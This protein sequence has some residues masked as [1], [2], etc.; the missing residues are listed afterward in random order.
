MPLE[1]Q[2]PLAGYY[3][4]LVNDLDRGRVL[5][6]AENRPRRTTDLRFR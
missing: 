3:F 6:A 4:T 5:F 2:T 1:N